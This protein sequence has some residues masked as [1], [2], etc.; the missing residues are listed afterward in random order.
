[1][2]RTPD[3]IREAGLERF[4]E[5]YGPKW[6]AGQEAH[7]GC[8]DETV[9]IEKAEEEALDLWAYL[10]SLRVK[11]NDQLKALEDTK[12]KEIEELEKQVKHYKE[13]AG[14]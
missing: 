10:Q 2:S 5:K 14:R 3:Q 8:L 11:H 7:G 6:N 4:V 13:L 12:N 1:M 9:T